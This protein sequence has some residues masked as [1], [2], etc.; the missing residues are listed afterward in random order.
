LDMHQPNSSESVTYNLVIVASKIYFPYVIIIL[1]FYYLINEIYSILPAEFS[2]CLIGVHWELQSLSLRL[3]P[4]DN[5]ILIW[6]SGIPWL[7]S[8]VVESGH[9]D[10]S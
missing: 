8:D 3:F 10:L 4:V 6:I 7:S 5:Y 9:F 2:D 1:K